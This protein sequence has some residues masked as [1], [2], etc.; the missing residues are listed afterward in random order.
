M[1]KAGARCHCTAVPVW[2]AKRDPSIAKQTISDPE[3]GDRVGV[4][5]CDAA[6][7][8]DKTAF[9]WL[10]PRRKVFE[11]LKSRLRSRSDSP[12]LPEGEGAAACSTDQPAV[13]SGRQKRG[14]MCRAVGNSG[15]QRQHGTPWEEGAES[16]ALGPRDLLGKS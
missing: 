3:V 7:A 14:W 16:R 8:G 6:P 2:A 4:K 13:P 11:A 9:G 10:Q 12:S 15:C 1:G 5:P